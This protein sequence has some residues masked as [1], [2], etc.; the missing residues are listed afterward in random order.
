MTELLQCSKAESACVC[1]LSLFSRKMLG[2]FQCLHCGCFL[3]PMDTD[4]F[5]CQHYRGVTSVI[6]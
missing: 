2:N 6:L 1:A 3:T 4:P 5:G